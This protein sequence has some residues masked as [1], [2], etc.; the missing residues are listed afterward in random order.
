ML[1]FFVHGCEPKQE[2]LELES[3][4]L[5]QDNFV[6]H[7]LDMCS[8][9]II[10]YWKWDVQPFGCQCLTSKLSLTFQYIVD[11]FYTRQ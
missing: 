7:L 3:S 8:S 10:Y 9:L 2:T 5:A 4:W 1:S 11:L 6:Q